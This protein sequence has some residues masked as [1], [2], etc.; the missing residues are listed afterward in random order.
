MPPADLDLADHHQQRQHAEQQGEHGRARRVVGDLVFGEDRGGERLES[1]R[2]ERTVLTEQVQAD[3]QRAAAQRRPG[4]RDGDPEKGGPPPVA[5]APGHL[6]QAGIAP[7][8]AGRNGQIDQRVQGARHHQDGA[9]V[10]AHVRGQRHPGEALDEFRNRQRQHQHH[11]EEPA[12]R[13]IGA[14][15]Q[16]GRAESDHRGAGGDGRRQRDGVPDQGCGQRPVQQRRRGRPA[17][18]H[19]LDHHEDQRKANRQ[20]H[21]RGEQAERCADAPPRPRQCSGPWQPRGQGGAQSSPAS[22]SR[23][24]A[25]WPSPRS[26]GDTMVPSGGRFAAEVTPA[27]S[28]YS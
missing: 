9:P 13:Q 8:E 21:R 7:A 19:R 2:R 27:S 4:E 6:L 23:V 3:Q 22:C 15:H 25:A 12:Q 26:A 24:S 16:V 18:V 11:R 14:L 20:Q 17:G 1:E 10:A 28:G 5:K